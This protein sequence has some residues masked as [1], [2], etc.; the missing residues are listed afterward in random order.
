MLTREK[1]TKISVY[2]MEAISMF[3]YITNQAN[4]KMF[5][6]RRFVPIWTVVVVITLLFFVTRIRPEHHYPVEES[7]Y[8]RSVDTLFTSEKDALLQWTKSTKQQLEAESDQWLDW[9]PV[10]PTVG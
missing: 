1:W 7:T 4:I 10:E 5:C 6:F 9:E 3:M 8:Y 2:M